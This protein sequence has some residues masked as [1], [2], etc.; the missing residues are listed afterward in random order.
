MATSQ[1]YADIH[2]MLGTYE[3]TMAEAGDELVLLLSRA[4][5]LTPVERAEL[6]G[7]HQRL[8]QPK[9]EL[10][11]AAEQ[12]ARRAARWPF[13]PDMQ[14]DATLTRIKAVM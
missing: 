14:L 3:S 2:A 9:A 10:D 8:V 12:Y 11:F 7:L 5:D 1:D 6:L 4:P 13:T